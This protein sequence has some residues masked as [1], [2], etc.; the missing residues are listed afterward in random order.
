MGFNQNTPR[1]EYIAAQ[2]QS[3]FPFAFKIY[4]NSDLVVY[5]TLAGQTSNDDTDKLVLNG[6]YSVTIDEDNGGQINL[7]TPLDVGDKLTILRDLPNTREIEYQTNGDLLATTLNQDQNYQTYLLGDITEKFSRTVSMQESAQNVSLKLPAPGSGYYIRWNTDATALENDDTPPLWIAEMET[8]RDETSDI[9]DETTV[10]KNAAISETT[11]I[12]DIVVAK[13]ALV[14]P[15]Y[16]DIDVIG[17]DLNGYYIINSADNGLIS[18][19]LDAPIDV[20]ES[21]IATVS[22]NIQAVIDSYANAAAAESAK[23][24]I[25]GMTAATGAAGTEVIWNNVTGI[26][27]V[28]KGDTGATGPQGIQGIQGNQGIQGIQGEIGPQGVA[29]SD[30]TSITNVGSS[31]TGSTTTVT[32]TGTFIGSPYSF[33]VE[34]GIVTGAA[35]DITYDNTTSGLIATNLQ[36]AVDEI[37]STNINTVDDFTLDLGGI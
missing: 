17:S 34:D 32:I 30:G 3:A 26:L 35:L 9:K 6:Q 14:N 27:T 11:A 16:S 36:A 12:K 31:K 10:I 20:A 22:E 7:I 28:P 25:L 5:K 21:H 24:T 33:D 19:A 23:D 4:K 29:G 18:E 37:V 1:A 8:L 2:G 15:Y 13:E